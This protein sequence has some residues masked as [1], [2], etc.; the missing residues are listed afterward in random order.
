MIYHAGGIP[1]E[2]YFSQAELLAAHRLVA[3]AAQEA[4]RRRAEP[5]ATSSAVSSA[6]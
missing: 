3:L 4:G 6:Q 2:P 1:D 5:R